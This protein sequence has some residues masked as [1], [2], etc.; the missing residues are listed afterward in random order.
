MMAM[1]YF[2]YSTYKYKY[3]YLKFVLTV[4]IKRTI[5]SGL[6]AHLSQFIFT[7]SAT[8][9]EFCIIIIFYVIWYF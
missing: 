9:V 7:I 2:Y 3:V 8:S 6:Q 1:K 4:S 5:P